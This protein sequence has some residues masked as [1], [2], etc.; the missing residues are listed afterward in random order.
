[1]IEPVAFEFGPITIR[2][3][4]LCIMTG[5]VLAVYL[6]MREGP[7][8]GI[9]TDDV[10][11]FILI[12]F[13]LSI[14]GAR[15]YYVFFQWPYSD[16]AQHP[17]EILAVWHGG[18]AIY[19]GLIT[20]ATVLLIFSY[21]RALNPFNFLD[22]AAPG[23]LLAQAVGRWGNFFNQEAYGRAVAHLN[24][25]PSFIQRQMF[26]E[27][28][29]RLPT[30]LFESLWNLLGFIIIMLVRHRPHFLKEGE[31][32]FFYLVW[33]GS[34]RFIIEGLRTDSLL[35]YGFRVSQCLSLLLVV[36]GI[37]LIVW[38]RKQKTIPYY[39]E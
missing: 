12:A 7:K 20:G 22:I 37:G 32:A 28:S 14:I 3:Y 25:L 15:L 31:A 30:F 23:V 33:Y 2:W 9:R 6:A 19:G 21:Y 34:G 16:Y 26:I 29:Y 17:G 27:G 8:K 10:L 35:F 36:L 24:Y 38:R 4:S 39:Q 1:M 5:L 11:D 18:L 13:P